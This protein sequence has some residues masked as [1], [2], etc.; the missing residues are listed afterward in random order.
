M[1]SLFYLPISSSAE[2]WKIFRNMLCQL[3]FA[4]ADIFS[5]K[6]PYFGKHL[7]CKTGTDYAHNLVYKTSRLVRI[8]LSISALNKRE[9]YSI[10]AIEN[11]FPVFVYPDINTRGAGRILDIY[12]NPRLP[13]CITVS[14]SPNPS[15]VY[16]R[17][18][19]HG[20]RFLLLNWTLGIGFNFY[21]LD[22]GRKNNKYEKWKAKY[23]KKVLMKAKEGLS[24]CQNNN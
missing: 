3:L 23:Q 14:N 1:T 16:I 13:V 9:S 10:K 8:S 22:N 7:F 20:K 2:T 12:A 17:L 15:R 19:K 24:C 18:C 6:N 5:E 11:V 21:K 4:W